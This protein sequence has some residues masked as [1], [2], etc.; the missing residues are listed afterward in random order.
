MKNKK[1]RMKSVKC[2]RAQDIS[3]GS[4]VSFQRTLKPAAVVS[5][6]CGGRRSQLVL[7]VLIVT[8]HWHVPPF[9]YPSLCSLHTYYVIFLTLCSFG[10]KMLFLTVKLIAFLFSHF[11][12][13]APFSM[14]W[15]HIFDEYWCSTQTTWGNRALKFLPL[16]GSYTELFRK[17]THLF[18]RPLCPSG[19]LS[20]QWLAQSEAAAHWKWWSF[21]TCD[22]VT[23]CNQL[24]YPTKS[25]KSPFASWLSS[26][27]G[28][29]QLLWGHNAAPFWTG[30][31]QCIVGSSSCSL[32]LSLNEKT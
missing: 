8:F 19:G 27:C 32:I 17:W 3:C 30:Q 21:I 9:H 2:Q 28:W 11:R 24:M 18:I 7:L 16:S 5:H 10:Y 14:S 22:M 6:D 4:S 13:W 20:H 31:S 26:F 23:R 15:C 1:Y 25:D 12:L 29:Q